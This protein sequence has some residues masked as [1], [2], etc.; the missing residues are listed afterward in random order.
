M[1]TDEGMNR[2][3]HFTPANADGQD[4]AIPA[5]VPVDATGARL[6]VPLNPLRTLVCSG[7]SQTRQV[8]GRNPAVST[9]LETVWS[10]GGLYPWSAWATP[11]VLVIVSDDALDVDVQ[12]TLEGLDADGERVSETL[13]TDALDGTTPVTGLTTFG[14]LNAAYVSNGVDMQAGATIAV[15]RGGTTVAEIEAAYQAASLGVYSV[16]AGSTAEVLSVR[17]G[18]SKGDE[19]TAIIASREFDGVFV[20]RDVTDVF[21]GPTAYEYGRHDVP[22]SG[23]LVGERADIELR[24]I[25]VT[26]SGSAVVSGGV[27]VVLR[28]VS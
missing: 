24:G 10:A 17:W 14:R 16:P 1:A 23:L 15:T 22:G 25:Q 20:A 8:V 27:V 6:G 7:C 3:G 11:G 18:T 28:P 2:T 21:D 9:S 5:M 4:V 13:T 19:V 12:V 26:G